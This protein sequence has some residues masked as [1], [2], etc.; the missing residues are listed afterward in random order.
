[1]SLCV[2]LLWRRSEVTA[3]PIADRRLNGIYSLEEGEVLRLIPLP[4]VAE[5][6]RHLRG[7][8]PAL[9]SKAQF[10]L[11]WDGKLRPW[12]QSSGGSIGSAIWQIG[13]ERA[14][15]EVEQAIG[16][17]PMPGD[18]VVRHTAP[19]AEKIR[20]LESI[21]KANLGRSVRIEKRLVEREVIDVTGQFSHTPRPDA[22]RFPTHIHLYSDAEFDDGMWT[23]GGS[24]S[25]AEFLG[26]LSMTID[27]QVIDN[28]VPRPDHRLAWSHY[29]SSRRP[30]ENEK[31][32]EQFLKNVSEQTSLRFTREKR[33]VEVYFVREVK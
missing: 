3:A 18:W 24:G 9:L 31:A 10:G 16:L 21:I 8:N 12:S 7:S 22:K 30:D 19:V 28:A 11:R 32:L 20:A 25:F 4:G 14:D 27:R 1:M 2:W 6:A 23:G 17:V 13:I 26:S 29:I 5:R 15:V 33:P